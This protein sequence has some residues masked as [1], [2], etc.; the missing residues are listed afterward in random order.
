MCD[1]FS[2]RDS[3][4]P[5]IYQ[6]KLISFEKTVTYCDD[7][8]RNVRKKNKHKNDRMVN[9]DFI[10]KEIFAVQLSKKQCKSTVPSQF[11]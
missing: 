4:K 6:T 1:F 9:Y 10:S 5:H 7:L 3:W 11:I 2:K 8:L